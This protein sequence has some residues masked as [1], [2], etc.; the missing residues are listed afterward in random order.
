MAGEMSRR[1]V[2]LRLFA[3]E[4][5]QVSIALPKSGG[6]EFES[7]LFL[8][9][10]GAKGS[11]VLFVGVATETD[12]VGM[13]STIYRMRVADPTGIAYVSAGQY[14]P[15]A[16]QVI[17]QLKTPAFVAVVGKIS[18]YTPEEG[19]VLTSIR[20]ERVCIV[21]ETTRDNWLIE[22]VLKTTERMKALSANAAFQAEVATAY[23]K[24][25]AKDLDEIVK[26]VVEDMA[27]PPAAVDAEKKENKGKG[28]K[29]PEAPKPPDTKPGEK[30]PE[31][32]PPA[33]KKTESPTGTDEE[34]KSFIKA[35]LIELDKDGKGIGLNKLAQVCKAHKISSK[36]F[37][38]LL[39]EIMEDGDAY[40]P[41]IGIVRAS[42]K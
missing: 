3:A 40:E 11:R 2:A 13:E 15:E 27:A 18:I 6:D 39:N 20:A 22:T 26:K 4:L 35:Q 16:A 30:K 28:E 21:D 5:S 17:A 42:P 36:K 33:E 29:T 41:K 34:A 23:P 8:T 1:L 9:P 31:T 10:T 7:Q 37:D 14:Q 19:K 12:T 32:K 24:F 38:E 25:A